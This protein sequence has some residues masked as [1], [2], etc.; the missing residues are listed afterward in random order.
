MTHL[1]NG[2][3]VKTAYLTKRILVSR[4]RK[5]VREAAIETMKIMGYVVIA[6]DGWIIKKYKD[7]RVERIEE[8]VRE[9]IPLTLD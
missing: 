3:K 2:K 5:A 9:N 6:E 4:S 7:G 8:I 1:Q